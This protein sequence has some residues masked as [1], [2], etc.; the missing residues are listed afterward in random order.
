MPSL[1]CFAPA[2]PP[3]GAHPST[4]KADA[5]P[6]A[7]E[8]AVGRDGQPYSRL[9]CHIPQTG[10]GLRR[11]RTDAHRLET[12]QDKPSRASIWAASQ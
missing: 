11:G 1:G 5:A 3:T 10:T 6:L 2:M 4:V 7:R 9:E 8:G 12:S